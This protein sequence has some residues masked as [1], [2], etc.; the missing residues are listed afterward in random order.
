MKLTVHCHM[1]DIGK[2]NARVGG[3]VMLF[4]RMRNL[5]RPLT[6]GDSIG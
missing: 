3:K 2:W 6:V 1:D 4:E 5:P